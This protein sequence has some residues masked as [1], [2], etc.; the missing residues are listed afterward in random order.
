MDADES[1]QKAI[2]D[3]LGMMDKWNKDGGVD[4]RVALM[5]SLSV[6][7]HAVINLSPT[8][9]VALKVLAEALLQACSHVKKEEDK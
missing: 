2:S 1:F 5:G 8:K 3:T 9:E 7:L 4:C 6:T